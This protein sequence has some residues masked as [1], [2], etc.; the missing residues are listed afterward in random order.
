MYGAG[1]LFFCIFLIAGL[2]GFFITFAILSSR[3]NIKKPQD[4]DSTISA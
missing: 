1:L 3:K 2:V 4:V